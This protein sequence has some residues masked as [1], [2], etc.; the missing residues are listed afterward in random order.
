MVKWL[1]IGVALLASPAVTAEPISWKIVPEQSHIRFIATQNHSPVKGEFARFEGDIAFHPEALSASHARI[2]V[3]MSSVTAAYEE[4]PSRLKQAD[5]FA[6]EQYPSAVFSTVTFKHIENDTY[7]AEA[8]L[9]I[10]EV[11]LPVTL[12]FTLLEFT[13]EQAKI[14][15]EATLQRTAYAVGWADTA[16]VEDAVKVQVELVATAQ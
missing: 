2:T 12:R 14:T 1:A 13:P 6:V 3:D 11:E 10:K 16:S 9:R 8:K 4:V 15:G 7:E 5:W